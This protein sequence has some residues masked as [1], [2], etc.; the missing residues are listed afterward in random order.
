M[1]S[2]GGVGV[3]TSGTPVLPRPGGDPVATS[4][5]VRLTVVIAAF[6]V[7]GQCGE[8]TASAPADLMALP[9]G[10]KVRVDAPHFNASFWR[11]IVGTLE[12]VRMD[13]LALRGSIAGQGQPRSIAIPLSS[14]EGIYRWSGRKGN[15]RVGMVVGLVVLAGVA[16]LTAPNKSDPGAIGFHNERLGAAVLGGLGGMLW[17]GILGSQIKTDR[18]E[19]VPLSPGEQ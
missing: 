2:S 7:L 9:T 17:G 3:S 4:C 13:T 6:V 14:I 15:G 16:A 12:A 19:K 1:C 10:T 18:W 11:P 5:A 8:S